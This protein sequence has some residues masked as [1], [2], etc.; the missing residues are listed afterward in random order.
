[1]WMPA[2]TTTP[3]LRVARS[4][5][6][7]SAPVGAKI[8]AASTSP[9]CCVESPAHAQPSESAKHCASKSPGRVYA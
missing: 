8:S 6:G 7:T 9:A 3:P 1:M 4:A 2:Q 5:A